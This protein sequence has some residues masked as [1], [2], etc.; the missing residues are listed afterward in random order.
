ME[1]LSPP[2]T[3]NDLLTWQMQFNREGTLPPNAQRLLLDYVSNPHYE[4]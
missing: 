3:E 1:Y 4:D 2:F